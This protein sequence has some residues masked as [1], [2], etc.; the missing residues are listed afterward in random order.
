MPHSSSSTTDVDAAVEGTLAS[1]CR[2]SG[3]TCVSANRILVQ[4]GI[5]ARF[6]EKLTAAAAELKVGEGTQEGVEQGP[7]INKARSPRWK[8]M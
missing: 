1:K 3:Q 4:D 8:R 7:L 2:N 6:A 5:Y